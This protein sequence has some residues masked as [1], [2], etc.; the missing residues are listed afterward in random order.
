[1]SWTGGSRSRKAQSQAAADARD[2]TIS[3]L[4]V[5]A[6]GHAFLQNLRRSHYELT[7]DLPAHNRIGGAFTELARY[8]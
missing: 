5:V 4:R 8:L 3:S 6:A 2:E 1:M 7:V